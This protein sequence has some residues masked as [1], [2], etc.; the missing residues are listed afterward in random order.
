M[1]IQ[2][3]AELKKLVVLD[4]TAFIASLSWHM[5]VGFL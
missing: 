1:F 5:A 3:C 2:L 4:V